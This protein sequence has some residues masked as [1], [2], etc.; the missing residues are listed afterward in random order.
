MTTII[1][2]LNGFSFA[3]INGDLTITHA[4]RG[5]MV[6]VVGGVAHGNGQ[7]CDVLDSAH[8]LMA[9]VEYAAPVQVSEAVAF[10][11]SFFLLDLS[12]DLVAVVEPRD[13]AAQLFPLA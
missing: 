7:V 6:T 11:A 9:R 4:E 5:G 8:R 2:D 13:L 1:T 10:P 3:A 12:G